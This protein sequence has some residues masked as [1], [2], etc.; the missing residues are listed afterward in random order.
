MTMNH[1]E[2]IAYRVSV[3]QHWLD[4]G[5]VQCRLIKSDLWTDGVPSFDWALY[6]YRKKPKTETRTMWVNV[7]EDGYTDNAHSSVRK[8]D[9][10]NDYVHADRIACIKVPYTVEV[11]QS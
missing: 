2:T 1:R 3:E 6:D 11:P 9:I 4:G 10:V 8:A 7:Y 5:E